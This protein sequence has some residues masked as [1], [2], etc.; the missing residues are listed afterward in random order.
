MAPKPS[1]S[2]TETVKVVVR[3]RPMSENEANDPMKHKKV[4][5][6]DE[7]SRSIT[8][9]NIDPSKQ[10]LG[11]TRD[12]TFDSVFAPNCKQES[13]FEDTALPIIESVL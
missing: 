1:T 5:H 4:V 6:V 3:C 12:F 7:S 2:K 13:V 10:H 8:V 9:Q 11:A